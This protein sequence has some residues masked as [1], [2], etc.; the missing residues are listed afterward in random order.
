MYNKT[1]ISNVVFF[2]FFVRELTSPAC[3]RTCIVYEHFFSRGA[4]FLKY[5]GVFR[6]HES[7]YLKFVIFVLLLLFRVNIVFFVIFFFLSAFLFGSLSKFDKNTNNCNPFYR[8]RSIQ[9]PN[10]IYRNEFNRISLE[11]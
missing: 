9:F 4:I 8:Y 11:L 1:D 3:R 10:E 6:N 5:S 2:F 7:S